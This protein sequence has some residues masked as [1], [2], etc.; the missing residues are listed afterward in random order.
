MP[1]P[2]DQPG[3]RTERLAEADSTVHHLRDGYLCAD[4]P[5]CRDTYWGH[6]LTL[7]VAPRGVDDLVRWFGTWLDE[8][9][10][11]GIGTAYLTDEA[12]GD[13][14]WTC[15]DAGVPGVRFS[16]HTNRRYRPEPGA[17]E[18]PVG[19]RPLV[20]DDD[21][22]RLDA[23]G[24]AVHGF[25]DDPSGKACATWVNR[26]RRAKT[27]E[28]RALQLGAFA[29]EQLVGMAAVVWDDELA[30]YQEVAVAEEHR[31][32]GVAGAMVRWLAEYV[33]RE[34]PGRTLWIN[35]DVGGPA[36][37]LYARLG[38][39][40][41]TTTRCWAMTGLLTEAEIE[42]RW[43]KLRDAS[44]P[45]AQWRHRDHLWGAV[46]VLAEHEG[47]VLAATEAL[48]GILQRLLAANGVVTTETEGYHETLTRGWLEL[49]ATL[50]RRRPEP[51][52]D[53]VLR[54]QL[55]LGDKRTLLRYWTKEALMSSVAR[56]SWLPPDRAPLD[57]PG[58]DVVEDASA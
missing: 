42:R 39:E 7:A 27:E 23:L 2:Y 48:R 44:L 56:R 6:R 17:W 32:Q 36:E 1:S 12:V 35:S 38:F 54:A 15:A 53:R 31:R 41:V 25:G 58:L 13:G 40:S 34:L 16:R 49:V 11:K 4:S 21:W 5:T 55:L 18:A 26:E 30:R 45:L 24:D 46:R 3:I 22:G 9:G 10:G 51:F 33:V 37:G 57:G 14:A 19:L 8:H 47:D 43:A 20:G 28:G 29:G 50:G 52:L